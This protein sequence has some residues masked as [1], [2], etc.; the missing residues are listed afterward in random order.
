M[1]LM[2][3]YTMAASA[4]PEVTAVATTAAAAHAAK[5]RFRR[6][7]ADLMMGTPEKWR[8]GVRS[9]RREAGGMLDGRSGMIGGIRLAP[10]T[11]NRE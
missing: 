1:F 11:M 9:L 3:L 4:P 6:S 2:P 10:R 8:D 7:E 5:W